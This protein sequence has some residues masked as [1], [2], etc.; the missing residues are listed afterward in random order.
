MKT[1][2]RF[3]RHSPA[4]RQRGGVTLLLVMVL[5]VLA[6][7]VGVLAVRGATA[8]LQMAGSQRVSRTGFYCAEAA[9]NKA[10][11][12]VA[13]NPADWT[14]I[15]AR[16]TAPSWWTGGDLTAGMQVDIDND[17]TYDALVKMIDNVDGD[18]D[19]TH[20]NDLTVI[21]TSICNSTKYEANSATR[22]LSQVVTYAGNGGTDY[23]YQAGHSSTHSGN[24]N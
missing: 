21:L 20:D 18:N 9:L 2:C 8:D 22:T 7:L 14:A 4:H 3:L 6:G 1:T 12:L 13:A 23:R 11:A 24:A 17:G 19:F 10:R 5:I 15:L 16:T